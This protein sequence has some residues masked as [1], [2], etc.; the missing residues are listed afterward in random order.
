VRDTAASG[1]T[2]DSPQ[3]ALLQVGD[4]VVQVEL[5]R[6]SLAVVQANLNR[7]SW[8]RLVHLE[9]ATCTHAHSH[10]LIRIRAE[11]GS[12]VDGRTS[13]DAAPAGAARTTA[14][15]GTAVSD[16]HRST[17][18]RDSN[19]SPSTAALTA[20][21]TRGYRSVFPSPENAMYAGGGGALYSS[22]R[23]STMLMD[24]SPA[25]SSRGT[26]LRSDAPARHD[27]RH[28]RTAVT[29]A[30]CAQAYTAH[31]QR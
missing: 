28:T 19:V 20:A 1:S 24:L 3:H 16:L 30:V 2:N 21:H 12:I 17:E 7:N 8:L 23:L 27:Q 25:P 11:A 31:T 4:R 15:T 10:A 9:G 14:D 13:I 5:R 6:E 26:R 22:A 18:K 29:H